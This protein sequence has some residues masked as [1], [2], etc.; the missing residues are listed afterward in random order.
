M[1]DKDGY[2]KLEALLKGEAIYTP[3]FFEVIDRY[4][5]ELNEEPQRLI[6][7]KTIDIN[8][9]K[10][11]INVAGIGKQIYLPSYNQFALPSEFP[12][13]PCLPGFEN[14][15]IK[16]MDAPK[17]KSPF[18]CCLLDT[19]PD[20]LEKVRDIWRG[21]EIC[22]QL[23]E[24]ILRCGHRTQ[25]VKSVLCF[26]L[27]A[28]A[29]SNMPNHNYRTFLQHAAAMEI[30][31]AFQEAQN[32]HN[33]PIYAQDPAYCA[34][35]KEVLQGLFGFQILETPQGFGKIDGDSF[36]VTKAPTAAVRQIVFDMTAHCKGPA[37][38]LCDRIVDNGLTNATI[39]CMADPCS[40]RAFQWKQFNQ[41]FNVNLDD[42]RSELHSEDV[43]LHNQVFEEVG[44]YLKDR[45]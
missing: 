32:T 27:G 7:I 1:G 45:C 22:R 9:V 5:N 24:H 14:T 16:I 39:D 12:K 10:H 37:G 34:R 21:S 4:Y 19:K 44:L 3:K 26:G 28:L 23:R 42:T 35:C 36:V 6:H 25:E 11:H 18:H 2:N 13:T 29:C 41:R 33:I 8:K 40:P 38:M 15:L 17:A 31:D 20:T 30:R 43:V